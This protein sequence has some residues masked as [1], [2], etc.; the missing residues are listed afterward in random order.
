VRFD[1]EEILLA[2]LTSALWLGCFG[3]QIH[4]HAPRYSLLLCSVSVV[5][6][7]ITGA[8]VTV[9]ESHVSKLSGNSSVD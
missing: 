2:I 1:N 7:V 6:F 5:G 4:R 8:D 3:H 9:S